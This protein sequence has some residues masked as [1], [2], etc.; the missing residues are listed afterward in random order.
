[1]K[2]VKYWE[3]EDGT[4]FETYWECH[5]YERNIKLQK[6]K[7]DFIFF[8]ESRKPLNINE[9]NTANVNYLIVKTIECAKNL[10]EWFEET[11]LE[12]PFEIRPDKEK[13][14]TFRWED[15]AG[16]WRRVEDELAEL[17]RLFNELN[18]IMIELHH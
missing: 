3:A 18:S 17:D 10:E 11:G 13:I 4:K 5:Q 6:F 9:I 2:E 14:G 15:S 7:N 1:M 16:E 12:N 8:D